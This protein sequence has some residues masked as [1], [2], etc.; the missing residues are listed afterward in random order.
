MSKDEKKKAI[1]ERLKLIRK[2]YKMNQTEFAKEIAVSTTT[3]CQ[4]E[5]GK[6]GMSRQTRQLLCE[7]F[8]VNLEWL[9]TGEGTMYMLIDPA[10]GADTIILNALLNNPALLSAVKGALKKFTLE[11][12]LQL[13][14]RVIN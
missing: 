5:C 1:G 8:H 2:S 3:V 9:D 7:R 10:E 13:M 12:W 6:Y 4:L 11:D 14:A